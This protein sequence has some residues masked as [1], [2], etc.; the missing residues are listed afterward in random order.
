MQTRVMLAKLPPLIELLRAIGEQ[1]GGKSAAQVAINW[2][3][4]KGTLP[5]PGAKNAQQVA[6]QRR[7]GRLAADRRRNRRTG[8]IERAPLAS[9]CKHD[10]ADFPRDLTPLR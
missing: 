8:R 6:A 5:I 2:T 1:H 10:F 3:I 9:V 7:S 4:C